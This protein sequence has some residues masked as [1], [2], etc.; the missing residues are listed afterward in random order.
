MTEISR[1][2]DTDI[3]QLLLEVDDNF[4]DSSESSQDMDVEASESDFHSESTED[5]TVTDVKW[6]VFAGTENAAD[7]SLESAPSDSDMFLVQ[8]TAA[9]TVDV[10]RSRGNWSRALYGQWSNGKWHAHHS[11]SMAYDLA[12]MRLVLAV[13]AIPANTKEYIIEHPP[14]YD[15]WKVL[16]DI[17]NI[18]YEFRVP[19]DGGF[20]REVGGRW[21]G[22]VGLLQT[23][24]ADLAV[25]LLTFIV[26]RSRVMHYTMPLY[27]DRQTLFVRRE[28][29]SRRPE[30]RVF[31]QP[32]SGRLWA[33]LAAALLLSAVS[34]AAA[35]A[36]RARRAAS[37]PSDAFLY[38]ACV[39]TV[40]GSPLVE[41]GRLSVRLWQVSATLAAVV[42]HAAF[43][44]ALVATVAAPSHEPPFSG[45]HGL[46][47]SD[48]FSLVVEANT[49]VHFYF[50]SSPSPAVRGLYER[51]LQPEAAAA[52]AGRLQPSL[53]SA[54]SATCSQP[55][56]AFMGMRGLYARMAPRLPCAL[57]EVPGAASTILYGF[58]VRLGFPY[59]DV[60]NRKSV[61]P[62][63]RVN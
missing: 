57:A 6:I 11:P 45:L 22:L 44:G 48:D 7:Y 10:W 16:A 20:G 54:F 35:L 49:S 14:G 5:E 8:A 34:L 60:L 41:S 36:F 58:G 61:H 52:A 12:G 15:F 30:W 63:V 55:H 59:R 53:V 21:G 39:F 37:V 31:V 28:Q 4:G 13:L 56:A 9:T 40:E 19:A 27:A 24:D 26:E 47:H 38:S 23:G 42:V 17:S 25:E 46:L 62:L 3:E 18:T 2:T 51:W 33:A 32:L 50:Q 43:C 29:V 1:V